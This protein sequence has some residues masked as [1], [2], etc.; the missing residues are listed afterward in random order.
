MVDGNDHEADLL[1]PRLVVAAA[2]VNDLEEP[3]ELLAARR[4][5]PVAYAGRWEFPGGKVEQ[6]EAPEEALVREI[7]EELGVE[8][9]LG[10][11]LPGPDAYGLGAHGGVIGRAWPLGGIDS[12]GRPLVLRLWL[13]SVGEGTP[14]MLEDH[15]ELAWLGP[16]AWREVAWVEADR[17]IVDALIEEVV[18]KNRQ[19]WC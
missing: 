15:D 16:G 12:N 1:R 6:G 10:T 13:A 9:V 4:S 8:I 19:S 7:R 2:I 5:R 17:V 3:R 14:R 11:E 18:R